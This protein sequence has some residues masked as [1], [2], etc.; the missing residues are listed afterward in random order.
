M[1]LKNLLDF[2]WDL[3]ARFNLCF[4]YL[5]VKDSR[6]NGYFQWDG[7]NNYYPIKLP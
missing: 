5:T 2:I 3:Y 1:L 4:G 7:A 6:D